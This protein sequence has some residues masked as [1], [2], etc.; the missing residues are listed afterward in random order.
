MGARIP[1]ALRTEVEAISALTDAFCAKRLDP[2]YAELCRR[3][4]E[5]LARKRPSPL[6]RGDLRI[7]A[8]AVLYTV[9]SLNFLFDRSQPHHLSVGELNALTGVPRS[10][11]ANKPKQ[12]RELLGLVPFNCEFRHRDLLEQSCL[13][14]LVVMNGIVAAA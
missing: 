2:E 13:A 8:A 3:L 6:V 1:K 4:V 12:I 7:W 5:K 14:R 9:G 10:T 11:M